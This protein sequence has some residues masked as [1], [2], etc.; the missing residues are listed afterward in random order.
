MPDRQICPN[1]Y[2]RE[3][4]PAS[5]PGGGRIGWFCISCDTFVPDG[6]YISIEQPPIDAPL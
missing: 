3:M 2:P 6:G 1:C 4:E 5:I